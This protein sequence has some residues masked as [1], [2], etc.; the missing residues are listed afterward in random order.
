MDT[1]AMITDAAKSIFNYCRA[2]TNSREDAED[3]SQD[4]F[5]ELLRA[6]G[7]LREEGAFYGF[8][9]AVAGNVY[10]GWLRKKGK[11]ISAELDE[12]IPASGAL[13][14]ELL[15]KDEDLR[16]LHRELALLSERE[17]KAVVAYY[18]DGARVA[19]IAK[20]QGISESM[21]KFLLFKSRKIL[22][23]GF[24][25]ERN[26]GERSFNPGM[27]KLGLIG[28][29]WQN[30]LDP[31]VF[32]RN[33]LGQ[34]ILLACYNDFCTAEEI[35]LQ[36]GVAVP[37][38][39]GELDELC[40]NGLLTRRGAKYETAIVIFTKNFVV[41]EQAK[42][43]A[44]QR[45]LAEIITGFLDARLGEIKAVG[46]H[47]P[48]DGLLRWNITQII[49]EQSI[50]ENPIMWD[51]L[52]ENYDHSGRKLFVWGEEAGFYGC[53]TTRHN[54]A[55]GD[56]LRFLEAFA[57]SFNDRVFDFG[58]FWKQQCRVDLMLGI[59]GGRDNFGEFEWLEIAELIKN[60]WVRQAHGGNR[61]HMDDATHSFEAGMALCIPVYTAAQLAEVLSLAAPVI[62]AVAE[63]AREMLAISAEILKQHT[64]A[65]KKKE[66]TECAFLRR[67]IIAMKRPIEIMQD[68]GALRRFTP[69]EHPMSYAFLK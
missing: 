4:I 66:A 5:L 18:F 3:L 44:L 32:E 12:N 48:G 20:S 37:Y 68:S 36:L 63:K 54:N 30:Y 69:N 17:R 55:Q 24:S 31:K 49:L 50:V 13:L 11:F 51:Y 22:K 9:W 40:R 46:F 64:P 15:E 27:L 6:R 1:E 34:N 59:A 38:L 23:E 26:Y 43:A 39:E 14:P 67:H 42:T 61:E 57:G 8:M 2:R 65:A 16:R 35:S 29:G 58:Y 53:L 60:G 21:V 19:A 25:M 33:L 41:E 28:E 45:E 7:N 47:S 52:K 62:A 56:E 10:K